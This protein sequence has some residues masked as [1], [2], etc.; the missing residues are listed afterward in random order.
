MA[1]VHALRPVGTAPSADAD[2]VDVVRIV[3][4]LGPVSPELVLVDPELA[5]RA[6][7]V[8]PELARNWTPDSREL[9]VPSTLRVVAPPATTAHWRLPSVPAL[10]LAGGLVVAF[11][12][13][14]SV[15]ASDGDELSALQSRPPVAAPA[16]QPREQSTAPPTA[17]RKTAKP[18]PRQ[19]ASVSPRF[20]WPVAKGATGY[21]VALYAADRQIFEQDVKRT[22][23]QLPRSWTYKGRFYSLTE[24]TYRWIVWPLV[25]RGAKARQGSAIVSASYT[26]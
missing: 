19:P 2:P 21:R 7:A 18:R 8:L 20:V 12:L 25:G 6:R 26:V 11:L 4:F 1:V 5:P 9:R 16:T 13:G 22:A 24:G 15:A 3:E 10:A 23:L 14:I 17:P